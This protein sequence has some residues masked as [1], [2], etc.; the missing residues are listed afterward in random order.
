[1]DIEYPLE[2][3]VKISEKPWHYDFILVAVCRFKEIELRT[4]LVDKHTVADK[5]LL[6]EPTDYI[7]RNLLLDAFN[8][9]GEE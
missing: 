4:L 5:Y 3:K 9:Q 7:I 2:F 1:M 6:S 8:K